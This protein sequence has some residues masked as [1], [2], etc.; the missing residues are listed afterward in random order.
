MPVYYSPQDPARYYQYQQSRNDQKMTNMLQMMMQ[1]RALKQRQNQ[2]A[3]QQE[4]AERRQEATERYYKYLAKP[5]PITPSETMKTIEYMVRTGIAPNRKDAYNLYKGL[6]DPERIKLEAQARAEGTQLGKGPD[7]PTIT[8]RDKK[9]SDLESAYKAGSITK[10]EYIQGKKNLLGITSSSRKDTTY[11][12][13]AGNERFVRDTLDNIGGTKE[14]IKM[15]R[16][17]VKGLP[18]ATPISDG[19]RIDMPFKYGVA[20]MNVEDKGQTEQDERIIRKYDK[21]FQEFL[22]NVMPNFKNFKDF[23][24][25]PGKGKDWDFPQVKIW[26]EIYK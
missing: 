19:V 8:D 14:I 3:Q 5:K 9:K 24:S 16:G 22:D 12:I 23:I 21:M 17:Q 25:T 6:K 10:E 26:F 4:L 15:A 2:F 7:I 20:K 13:R 18:G 11:T 1:M